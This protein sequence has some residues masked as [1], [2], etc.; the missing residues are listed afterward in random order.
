MASVQ[1]WGSKGWSRAVALD[2][3][4]YTG[5]CRCVLEPFGEMLD[6]NVLA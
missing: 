4:Q 5:G 2:E 1:E 3:D 6:V